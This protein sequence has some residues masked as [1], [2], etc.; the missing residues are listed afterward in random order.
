LLI[1]QQTSKH[2]RFPGINLYRENAKIKDL[3]NKKTLL[4]IKINGFQ[5]NKNLEHYS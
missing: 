1:D 5:N 3:G 4:L 2:H